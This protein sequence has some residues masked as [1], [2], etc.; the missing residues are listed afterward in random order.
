MKV[1]I[2]NSGSSS[3]KFQLID[4]PAETVLASGLIERIG[5]E[6]GIVNYKTD[7]NQKKILQPIPTHEFGLKVVADLL[8]NE[9]VGVIKNA[10][11]IETVGHRVVHGGK[12]FT[13]TTLINQS[14]KDS[15]Q[16]LFDLAPLHNP[17]NLKGIEV[18]ENIFDKAQQIA[19]FDTS[20]HQTMPEKAYKYALADDFYTE[21]DIRVYG[22]HGISHKY[23][24]EKAIA[25][26]GKKDSKIICLHLGNGCSATAV[27]NGKSID[28]SLGFGPNEGFIMGTRTGSLDQGIIFYLMNKYNYSAEEL[29]RIFTKESGMLGMTGFSDLRDIEDRAEKGD[30]KCQL[31]LEMNAYRIK[32]EIGSYAAAMNG[33]DALVFTAGIGENS[34][35][36]RD[37]VCRDMDY[38][39][40]EL[41]PELNKIRAKEI[42]EIQ[43]ETA[44]VKI[45]VIP[46][47]EELEIAKQTFQLLN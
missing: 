25:Y 26:L 43:K 46:T 3:I 29:N 42:R 15:I 47:N 12:K 35:I 7:Q 2:I 9:E 4:M 11:E 16:E 14:V 21:K 28:H 6:E 31:A 45:I 30:E 40:I 18:A 22:F 17:A 10:D 41:N 34:D 39:G 13:Q 32:K 24:S 33:L 20:F 38:F 1:L 23:V 5:L 27:L 19:V 44:R 37:L 8:Q 36:I